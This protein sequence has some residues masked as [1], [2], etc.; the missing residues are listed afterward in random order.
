MVVFRVNLLSLEDEPLIKKAAVVLCSALILSVSAQAKSVDAYD[1]ADPWEA[2]NRPMFTFNYNMDRYVLKPVAKGYRYVTTQWIRNRVSAASANLQEPKTF[3]NY[4]LQGEAKNSAISLGR[5]AVNSTLGLLG[6]FDVATGWGWEVPETRFDY[7]LGKYCVPDGPFL[8][9]PFVPAT[10]PR[11]FAASFADGYANPVYWATK[12]D[13]NS[14]WQ[15]GIYYAADMVVAREG[16][17]EFLD[18]LERNSV[19]FYA[20]MRTMFLQNRAKFNRCAAAKTSEAPSYDFD[21]DADN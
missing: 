2:F 1:V 18:E 4:V 16:T 15:Y 11:A 13:D 5:F 10:T 7:T 19:D 3:I 9:L 12:N 6:A 14:W 21:F 20:T 17:I 8:V